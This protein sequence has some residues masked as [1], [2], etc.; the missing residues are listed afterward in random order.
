MNQIERLRKV[1]E[2]G[3]AIERLGYTV[4]VT[5]RTAC[6]TKS[7]RKPPAKK[8]PV[9]PE[10][11]SLITASNPQGKL[12]RTGYKKFEKEV[13]RIMAVN[14]CTFSVA[15]SLLMS[16]KRMQKGDGSVSLSKKL[17]K[18]VKKHWDEVREYAAEHNLPILEAQTQLRLNKK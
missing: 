18:S 5:E 13:R 17:S 15:R 8:S 6:P 2:Y 14:G 7:K 11:S 12:A 16:R 10:G 4:L 1:V 3:T 9:A